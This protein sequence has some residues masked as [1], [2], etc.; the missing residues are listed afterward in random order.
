MHLPAQLPGK[1]SIQ[2]TYEFQF[3]NWTTSD[4]LPQ[5]SINGIVQDASGF[6]WIATNDGLTRFDGK[7]FKIFNLENTEGIIANRFEH[8]DIAPDGTIWLTC[9]EGYLTKRNQDGTFQSYPLPG[10]IKRSSGVA[11]RKDNT[12][13]VLLPS[14]LYMF[15]DEEEEFQSLIDF[16]DSHLY[17]TFNSLAIDRTM[18]QI[19]LSGTLGFFLM[20]GEDD[21]LNLMPDAKG[22]GGTFRVVSSQSKGV[23]THT[24]NTFYFFK[25]GNCIDTLTPEELYPFNPSVYCFVDS[26]GV[27]WI[28]GDHRGGIVYDPSTGEKEILST[29]QGLSSNQVKIFFEDRYGG[30]WFGTEDM[31]LNYLPPNEFDVMPLPKRF[32]ERSVN[33]ITLDADSN[34]WISSSCQGVIVV[35]QEQGTLTHYPSKKEG[36]NRAV[37]NRLSTDCT[38]TIHVDDRN[39]VWIGSYGYGLH[40]IDTNRSIHF[41]P[42]GGLIQ[43]DNLII[44]QIKEDI[45]IASDRDIIRY[46]PETD[47]FSSVSEEYK[48]PV[49]YVQYLFEDSRGRVWICSADGI[50]LIENGKWREFS[51]E[52]GHLPLNIFRYAYETPGGHLWFG[53]YGKGMFYFDEP[54]DSFI[55]IDINKGSMSKTVSWI[56]LYQGRLWVTSNN[57]LYAALYENLLEYVTGEREDFDVISFIED[58]GLKSDEFNGGFQKTGFVKNGHFYLPTVQG[59][60]VFNPSAINA[61]SPPSIIFDEVELDGQKINVQETIELPYQ[62]KRLTVSVAS[63]IFHNHH[64]YVHEYQLEGFDPQW[65]SLDEDQKISFT[66]IPFG[67]YRLHVRSRSLIN[68]EI[69]ESKLV[70]HI[71]PPFWLN[72]YFILMALGLFG[73]GTFAILRFYNQREQRKKQ[74][75]QRLVDQRTK[76]LKLSRANITTIIE[77]SDD[78]IW[79]IDRKG[80]LIYA[81]QNYINLY[82]KV[83][84]HRLEIGQ[85]V[86]EHA[87]VGN[88]AYWTPIYERGFKGEKFELTLDWSDRLG[89]RPFARS[90]VVI[91]PVHSTD[92]EVTG[93]VAFLTDQTTSYLRQKELEK[94]KEEA[95]SAARSKSEF[96]AT[97]SH[98]IRTPMNGV[99]GMTSL[100]LQTDLNPEQKDYI[101]TIRLSGDN[102][103]TIINEILDF[104][105]IDSGQM[106]VEYQTFDLESLLEETFDL[107]STHLGGKEIDLYYDWDPKLPRMIKGDP[108]RLRQILINLI[109]NAIKFTHEGYVL[110]DI[111]RQNSSD[112]EVSVS[113]EVKDTGIGIPESRIDRLFKPFSQVDSSTTRKYGGTGL[114]LAITKKLVELLGGTIKVESKEGIGSSFI[115]ELGFERIE[116]TEDSYGN[117]SFL[118]GHQIAVIASS[119]VAAKCLHHYFDSHGFAVPIYRSSLDFLNSEGSKKLDMLFVDSRDYSADLG[120]WMVERRLNKEEKKL[121]SILLSRRELQFEGEIP[122]EYFDLML[123]KPILFRRISMRLREFFQDQN[124]KEKSEKKI[125][126]ISEKYPVKILVAEDNP[127]NQKMAKMFMKKLGYRCDTAGNGLEAVEAVRRQKYDLIFMDIQMPEMDGYEATDII[128]EEFQEPD[129]PVIIAMTAN[130]LSTDREKCLAYGMKDYLSKPVRLEQVKEMIEKWGYYLQN[131]ND[132]NA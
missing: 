103:I 79:S 105:K 91:N 106:E 40:R 87:K 94:A 3:K 67:S 48:L 127:I 111:I 18:D 88:K 101:E 68:G 113:F 83:N 62:Y 43:D 24:N 77:E 89:T 14:G 1:L 47:Q 19:Y 44:E 84:K 56:Q 109:N 126:A 71:L 39:Q 76:D 12:P 69:E 130:A 70:I 95:L 25:D 20:T 129:A 38:R 35:N 128:L 52:T 121:T 4:G 10:E 37:S 54:R 16:K 112:Q 34:I 107:L 110:L 82:E 51:K 108:T 15:L 17:G 8:I 60:A 114:G 31:G 120:R 42:K 66:K 27:Y 97:M 104:S 124:Q 13:I 57:G 23:V 33:A 63:P 85:N 118:V 49:L 123:N 55:H 32:M 74:A 93:L 80:Y 28:T 53:S 132:K 5:N 75:L 45:W 78:L 100:L 26:K 86:L 72:K 90:M 61:V 36:M 21:L 41:Y 7:N 73:F 131:T 125:Q 92:G 2:N 9:T 65:T 64:N 98:E 46:T 116:T 81:N 96:L 30:M 102:L 11:I 59:V 29:F 122:D 119:E 22:T 6:L 58:N 117:L 99:I 50:F 115:F